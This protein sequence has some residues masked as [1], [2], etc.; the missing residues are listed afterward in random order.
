MDPLATAQLMTT[1]RTTIKARASHLSRRK[2]SSRHQLPR[3]PVNP[4]HGVLGRHP[5]H[6]WAL[7]QVQVRHDHFP[8]SGRAGKADLG[9]AT[10]DDGVGVVAKMGPPPQ[11]RF[12]KEHERSDVV[13]HIVC[14]FGPERG[15]VTVLM[16]AR[17]RGT[18]VEGTEGGKGGNGVPG[19]DTHEGQ[20][21]GPH[22]QKKPKRRITSRPPIRALHQTAQP[23]SVNWRSVPLGVN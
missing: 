11:R 4:A 16:P 2:S 1:S 12:P 18:A 10:D 19:A 23:V 22:Q 14:P 7:Y 6:L 13:N 17:I 20:R 8:P 21:P 3:G 9:V 15:A 5:N